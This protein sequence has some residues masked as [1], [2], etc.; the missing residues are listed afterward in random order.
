MKKLLIGLTVVLAMSIFAGCALTNEDAFDALAR[1]ATANGIVWNGD[2]GFKSAGVLQ[3]WVEIVYP[4]ESNKNN[5]SGEVKITSNS[6]SAKFPDVFFRWDNKQRDDGFLKID[7]KFFETYEGFTITKKVSNTYWDYLITLTYN[8]EG[9]VVNKLYDGKDG[10]YYI[11]WIPKG[12]ANWKWINLGPNKSILRLVDGP[13]NGCGK[14]IN[15]VFLWNFLEKNDDITIITDDPVETKKFVIEFTKVVV[16]DKGNDVPLANWIADRNKFEF[17]LL[18]YDKPLTASPDVDGVVR[19]EV[20]REGSFSVE[21]KISGTNDYEDPGTKLADGISIVNVVT[22]VRT[23]D[24]ISKH[25]GGENKPVL[26][27]PTNNFRNEWF[28]ANNDIDNN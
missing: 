18:G 21:E 2:E 14:N 15:M 5:A 10:Q 12:K 19:F 20:S 6:H 28:N 3:N 17:T 9:E 26:V 25:V 27:D 4:M 1:K 24:I 16:D 11:F 23:I 22:Q 13:K 7:P 8:D